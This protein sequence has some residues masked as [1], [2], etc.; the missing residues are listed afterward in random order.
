MKLNEAKIFVFI[1]AIIVGILIALNINL[2][3]VT[4]RVFLDSKQYQ[5]AY[6]ERNKLYREISSIK[7]NYYDAY[8]KLRNYEQGNP[9]DTK[10]LNDITKE[11]EKNKAL[12]GYSE[13][14]GPGISFTITDGKDDVNEE[15][16]DFKL[17]MDRTFHNTDMIRL[18]NELK[19]VGAEAIS[20]NGQRV[21]TNTEIYCSWAFLKINGVNLPEP[22]YIDVIGDKENIKK[23]I[24]SDDSYV[25]TLM[26][27]GINIRFDEK[28]ELKIPAY[29]G[30]LQVNYVSP[31]KSK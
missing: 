1:A 27:R 5:E 17:R 28:D 6:N 23:Y 30:K 10:V 20:V 2:N 24:S 18:L 14:I 12:L 11:L 25:K 21:M 7:E 22:F 15:F 26:F 31:V 29:T 8:D 16:D 9:N 4:E 19:N 3:G 13:V